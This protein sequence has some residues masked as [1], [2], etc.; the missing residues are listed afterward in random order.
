M[1]TNTPLQTPFYGGVEEGGRALAGT[2]L[3]GFPPGGGIGPPKWAPLI[4]PG[5]AFSNSKRGTTWAREKKKKTATGKNNFW[6][7]VFL[8]VPGGRRWVEIP[9]GISTPRVIF[10]EG[11]PAAEVT[12]L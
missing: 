3:L 4:T 7:L 8:R 6:I 9:R 11:G 5:C 10:G 12:I 2:G 1:E